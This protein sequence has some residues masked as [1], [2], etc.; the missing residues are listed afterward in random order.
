MSETVNHNERAYLKPSLKGLV[1]I[2]PMRGSKNGIGSY[3]ERL[4]TELRKALPECNILGTSE[5]IG[6]GTIKV[7]EGQDLPSD[8][9]GTLLESIDKIHPELVHIQHGLYMGHN[10]KMSFFLDSLRARGITVV[11]TLHGVWPS[12][13]IRRWPVTFYRMLAQKVDKVIV[14]QDDKTLKCLLKNGI[15]GDMIDII[16]HG[17]WC[18]KEIG[19]E[20]SNPLDDTRNRRVVLFAGNIFRRKGLH[21]VLNAFPAVVKKIGGACLVVVGNKRKTFFWD[22]L[23]HLWIKRK[24][25]GG[26]RE[27]W[28]L[29]RMEYVS[30]DEFWARI[31]SAEVV[32]FPYLRVYGSASG[33]FHRA[34]A[35]GRPVICSKVPTFWEAVEAWGEEL[36]ELFPPAGDVEAWSAAMIKIL[37]DDGL[38]KRATEASIML[39]HN[40]SWSVAAEKHVQLY[41]SILSSKGKIG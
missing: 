37:T 33:I 13:F 31:T 5:L 2:G 3:T 9:P 8:W 14:H 39:G 18:S 32:V 41:G 30:D 24:I 11:V 23:Y 26:K 1:L 10:N 19:N 28:L 20:I 36:K 22:N 40:T 7:K 35:A 38:R 15:P 25:N 34:L 21:I 6:T 27:G 12:S 17:T 16:P 29:D 4:I